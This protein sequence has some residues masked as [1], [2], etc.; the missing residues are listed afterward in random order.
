MQT[1]TNNHSAKGIFYV[2]LGAILWGVSGTIAQYVFTTYHA[3][4]VWVVG[5]RLFFAGSFLII[6]SLITDGAKVLQ[7][8]K[9]RHDTIILIL[10]GLLGM[11]PSQLCYFSAVNYSNAPTATVLQNLGPLFIIIY[12]AIISSKLPRRIDTISIVIALLGTFMLATNGHFDQLALTPR[13]LFWGVMA[14]VATAVYTLMPRH[15]LRKY[16]ARF[17]IGWAMLIGGLPF[18]YNTFT[19]T[20]GLPLT[21]D[22]LFWVAIIV[23]VG[24]VFTYY[25]YLSSLKYISATTT[26]MLGAFEP[27]TATILAVTV[28]GTPLTSVELIGGALILLTTFIQALGTKY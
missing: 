20:G 12:V 21:P 4:P 17:V 23:V 2:V 8:F 11:M 22:L 14:G 18:L 7:I 10:F 6:W 5:V 24:T 16:D 25:F 26:G 28:L 3:S 13:G 9:N 19:N 1:T 15:L 27:L